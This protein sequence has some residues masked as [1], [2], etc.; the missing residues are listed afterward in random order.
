MNKTSTQ[1]DV[2]VEVRF[3]IIKDADGY[4]ESRSAEAL[5]CKPMDPEC[6][7]C[8]VR[9]VPFF[10]KHVAYGDTI[11]T[12]AD[13]E[14]CLHFKT[15][16]GRGGY[17]VYRVFLQ[18][19]SQKDKVIERLLDFDALVESEGN[20]VALAVPPTADSDALVDYI[21]AGKERGSWGAQDGYIS[22]ST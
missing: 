18:D 6:K 1:D 20:L 22:E 12:T 19:P 7:T 17:S 10:L 4:P 13:P 11:T 14:G 15:V 8:V 5:L 21:L 2:V 9:S 3:E 16:T